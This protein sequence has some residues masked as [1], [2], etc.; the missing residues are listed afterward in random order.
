MG[1]LIG[2]QVYNYNISKT[3][4]YVVFDSWWCCHAIHRL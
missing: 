1:G 4:K 3:Q 2:F